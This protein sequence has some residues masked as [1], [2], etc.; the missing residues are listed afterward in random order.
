MNEQRTLQRKWNEQK[1]R[2]S[3]KYL[4]ITLQ[5]RMRREVSSISAKIFAC[6]CTTEIN[7]MWHCHFN[8]IRFHLISFNIYHSMASMSEFY[9]AETTLQRY[10]DSVVVMKIETNLYSIAFHQRKINKDS[11]EL[12]KYHFHHELNKTFRP[13]TTNDEYTFTKLE[14]LNSFIF[15]IL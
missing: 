8:P 1:N 9:T 11:F 7:S 14:I 12:N 13:T 3:N 6:R 4:F 2:E 15:D 5:L 10:N